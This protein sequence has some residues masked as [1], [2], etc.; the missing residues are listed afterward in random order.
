MKKN[1]IKSIAVLALSL[2]FGCTKIT[3][4]NTSPNNPPLTS[5]TPEILFPSGVASTSAR[6]GGELNI[7]GGFW[8]QYYTQY[9]LANQYRN[10]D[11]YNLTKNDLNGD[12]DELFA[13]ALEDYQLAITQAKAKQQ[14]NYVLM[15][16]VMKAYTY[17]V[18]ADL[19]DQVPY[20]QALTG[21]AN[22]Q[23]AFDK[24]HDIYVGLIAEID[25][26]LAQNYNVALSPTDA[27]TDFVFGGGAGAMTQWAEFA[28]TLELKMYLRMINTN[29][30]DAQ[31]GVAKLYAHPDFLSV[32]AG[33][34]AF[35]NTPNKDNPFYEYNIRSLNTTTNIKASSTFVTYLLVTQDP[36]TTPLFGTANP[37]GI[38]QGDY[39][40][41]NP[42]YGGATSPVQTPLDP[43][44]FIS[45]AESY[46]LRAEAV[47]RFG[48]TDLGGTDA[49]LYK[50]GIAASFTANGLSTTTAPFT[51]YTAQASV[52]Y[53]TGG[54]LA[55]KLQAIITQKWVSLAQGCHALEAFF[56]QERTGYPLISA[57][58][59]T[60]GTYV[61]G[62][63][64]YSL[65]GVTANKAFPKRLIFPKSE[66]DRNSNT[67]AQVPL[68][69]PVWWGK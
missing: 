5:A 69:T 35:A 51:T 38:N 62:Q 67:P 60:A 19:Y 58:Y 3:D 46:F 45:A 26:A 63:W 22:T 52:A 1:I 15:C 55:A 50:A 47:A 37:V 6:I 57:V 14:W 9:T 18:L 28:H 20:T 65:N 66:S 17:E 25:A 53:P 10:I 64:V 11:S 2:T 49:V 59:S 12:Y 54:T 39:N 13:G 56:E 32:N 41:T 33:M 24:G 61:P 8:A 27:P 43:V 16:T 4:I 21:Q 7:L 44:W 30:A 31:A 68:T 23:P 34:T 42:T 36:R 29:A 48:V 40:G